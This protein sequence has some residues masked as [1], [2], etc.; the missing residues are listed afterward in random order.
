MKKILE[1]IV[2][3]FSADLANT[4]MIMIWGIKHAYHLRGNQ[5]GML[6]HLMYNIK[7]LGLETSATHSLGFEVCDVQVMT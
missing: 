6:L 4:P 5:C 3:T 7:A 1:N 2:S